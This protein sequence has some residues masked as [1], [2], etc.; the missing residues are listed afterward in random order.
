MKFRL[1]FGALAF[2]S[3]LAGEFGVSSVASAKEESM[4]DTPIAI[5]AV[6]KEE[7]ER[8][9]DQ[10]LED[11]MRQTPQ[12]TPPTDFSTVPIRGM[13]QTDQS[14]QRLQQGSGDWVTGGSVLEGGRTV[15]AKPFV[16]APKD[17][18]RGLYRLYDFRLQ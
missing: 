9:V 10:R 12:N 1:M 13:G 2:F 5:D 17:N 14:Q 4:S 3:L 8:I 15:Y 7:I 11:I 16:R 6:S 18:H